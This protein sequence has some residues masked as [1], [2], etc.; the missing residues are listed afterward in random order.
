[1]WAMGGRL[2]ATLE[3]GVRHQ[4]AVAFEAG[5]R[6]GE[7]GDEVIAKAECMFQGVCIL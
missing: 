2:I 3:D 7:V 6:A 5:D 1:M 4:L